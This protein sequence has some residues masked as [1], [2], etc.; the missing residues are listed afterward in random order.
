M[1]THCCLPPQCEAL[2]TC[3]SDFPDRIKMVLWPGCEGRASCSLHE[4]NMRSV[5]FV[6]KRR[7]CC[8][9]LSVGVALNI[10][11]TTTGMCAKNNTTYMWREQATIEWSWRV[12][13]G[14]TNDVNDWTQQQRTRRV[15]AAHDLY[16]CFLPQCEALRTCRSGFPIATQLLDEFLLALRNVT[17]EASHRTRFTVTFRFTTTSR[18]VEIHTGCNIRFRKSR[19]AQRSF[20]LRTANDNSPYPHW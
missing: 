20:A 16:Y 8:Y 5:Q 10:W 17:G 18:Y 15:I 13:S 7:Q 1:W 19:P 4:K 2:R 6:I 12:I 3:R 11:F 9:N 14:D